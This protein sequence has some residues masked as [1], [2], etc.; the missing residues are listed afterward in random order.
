MINPCLAQ[1]LLLL[2]TKNHSFSAGGFLGQDIS[3]RFAQFKAFETF[4]SSKNYD[5]YAALI[6]SYTYVGAFEGWF[7][8]SNLEY[9]KQQP[10]PPVFKPFTDLGPQIFNTLR[11]SNLS[12]LA[13]ELALTTPSGIRDLFVTATFKNN[14]ATMQKYFDIANE[15]IYGSS[16]P[17]IHDIPGLIFSLSFQ[18]VPQTIIFQ[19]SRNGGN[20]LGLGTSDGDLV[21]VLLTIQWGL[22]K[23]DERVNAAAKSF[24]EKGTA[25]SKAAGTF[26]PYLYLNYAGE[27]QKPI[28]G[29]G[30]QIVQNLKAVSD[31]YDPGKTFQ[32]QV[33]GGFKLDD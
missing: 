19:A 21:N 28:A 18:P 9:T 33:P 6:N 11:I 20:S 2:E 14:A 23:D 27:F 15:T 26:N 29:Y 1:W 12:D 5:P 3:T 32:N 4:A 22:P 10:Y 7:I 13:L 31:K 17:S 8:S 25:A 16:L 24:I 30:P